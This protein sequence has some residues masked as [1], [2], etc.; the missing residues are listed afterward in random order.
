M[1]STRSK[2]EKKRAAPY[3]TISVLSSF[4]D[5]IR[6]IATPPKITSSSLQETGISSFD[7]LALLSALRFLNLIDDQGVPT[8]EFRSLQTSGDEF[9]ANLERV[10]R[11]AYSD[12]FSWQD[13]AVD[14]REHIRNFFARSYSPATAEK[15]TAVFYDLCAEASI[16]TK[17]EVPAKKESKGVKA[18]PKRKEIA[19]E[20]AL[21]E[22][23]E[24]KGAESKDF[25]PR[26]DIRIDSK[27]FISM[28]PEQIQALF[29][30]LS[31]VIKKEKLEEK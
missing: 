20:K 22:S 16:A 10:V 30:G 5:R 17:A 15:A 6:R 3:V 28:Q 7:S 29:E 26:F 31:K 9:K 1:A 12:L 8:P 25:N 13:P 4:L 14:D 21:I 11:N 24:T 2:K 23:S 19:K 18:S 27:D